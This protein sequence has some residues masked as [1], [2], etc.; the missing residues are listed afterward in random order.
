MGC[1][2]RTPRLCTCAGLSLTSESA[3]RA[4]ATPMRPSA[5]MTPART[6]SERRTSTAR[7]NRAIDK[8]SPCGADAPHLSRKQIRPTSGIVPSL[9]L[10]NRLVPAG[11]KHRFLIKTPLIK[12][13]FSKSRAP[14]TFAPDCSRLLLIGPDPGHCVTARQL[15]LVDKSLGL[16][17]EIIAFGGTTP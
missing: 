7:G 15:R 5:S 1:A 6:C 3:A 10:V 16:S 4:A 11:P 14:P 12:T 8:A 2:T 17:H 13:P 9:D